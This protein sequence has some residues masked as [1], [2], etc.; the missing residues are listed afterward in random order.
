MNDETAAWNH[1]LK[2]YARP[3]VAAELLRRQDEEGLDIV[4]HLFTIWL[5]ED[6]GLMLSE[7]HLREAG[8]LVRPWRE[9]VVRPL[10]EARRAARTMGPAGPRR[11]ALR[12]QIQRAELDAERTQLSLLCAWLD[13]VREAPSRP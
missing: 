10:R 13:G 6:C 1:A 9:H 3:G 5:R 12:E 4:L 8:E 11:D 7:A 2:L